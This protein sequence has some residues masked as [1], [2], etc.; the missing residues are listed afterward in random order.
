MA[1]QY[2]KYRSVYGI[3]IVPLLSWQLW[4]AARAMRKKVKKVR[5]ATDLTSDSVCLSGFIFTRPPVEPHVLM[6]DQYAQR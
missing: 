5:R 2:C 1:R 4:L 6:L 3:G